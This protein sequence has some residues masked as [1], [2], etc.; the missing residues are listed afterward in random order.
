[1]KKWGEFITFTA[2]ALAI[3]LII[4]WQTN[5]GAPLAAGGEAVAGSPV[6]A[7]GD[8]SELIESWEEQPET[9]EADE[10]EQSDLNDD[11]VDQPDALET[12]ETF[13][14]SALTQ[15]DQPLSAVEPV[16]QPETVKPATE[17]P[18]AIAPAQPLPSQPIQMAPSSDLPELSLPTSPVTVPEALPL[19]S[20]QTPRIDEPDPDPNR[21][22]Q[23][24]DALNA[25][26]P[27]SQPDIRPEPKTDL[28]INVQAPLPQPVALPQPTQSAPTIPQPEPLVD[29]SG[30]PLVAQM[31]RSKPTP[32]K[33]EQP[34]KPKKQTVKKKPTTKKKKTEPTRKVAK[35][36]PEKPEKPA[37]QGATSGAPSTTQDDGK[38]GQGQKTAALAPGAGGQVKDGG[39]SKAAINSARKTFLTAVRRAVERKKRYPKRAKRRGTTGTAKI[40]I[41]LDASGRLV[42]ASMTSSSGESILDD[43]AMAAIKRVG[44]FPKIP[45]EM[46]QS[47]VKVTLPIAFRLR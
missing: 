28:A 38:G 40:R 24:P 8:L 11:A 12:P 5:T 32:P 35:K 4:A 46:G 41:T 14:V 34:K 33:V 3:H 44:R 21:R 36:T 7:A 26:T 37:A 18:N 25:L 27:D 22:Q 2:L 17:V 6:G 30:A 9:S 23:D 15:P 39:Y 29:D 43:A 19:Q 10:I 16:R 45:E 31:P 47:Q 1:M 13:E 42:S 20:T